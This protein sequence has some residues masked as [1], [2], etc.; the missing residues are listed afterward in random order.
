M[1][2]MNNVLVIPAY[3]HIFVC[4]KIN[5]EKLVQKT[6]IIEDLFLSYVGEMD[7]HEDFPE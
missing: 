6:K 2:I 3:L 5:R 4:D 1:I 7:E